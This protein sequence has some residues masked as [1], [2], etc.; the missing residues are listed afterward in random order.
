MNKYGND[1]TL[2]QIFAFFSLLVVL[3]GLVD[4]ITSGWAYADSVTAWQIFKWAWLPNLFPLSVYLVAAILAF[5]RVWWCA[6][7]SFLVIYPEG[8]DALMLVGRVTFSGLSYWV[9]YAEV[10]SR[11]L[12]F[13]LA[14][15]LIFRYLPRLIRYI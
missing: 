5:R 11:L 14:L 3:V 13:T 7:L 1:K 15:V 9:S 8:Y 2:F 10:V 4:I 6:F 12:Y